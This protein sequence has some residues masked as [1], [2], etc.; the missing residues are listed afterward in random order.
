M[1]RFEI[2][3]NFSNVKQLSV[4]LIV[5]S[6]FTMSLQLPA[7]QH[8]CEY[9][10]KFNPPIKNCSDIICP[11][12]S[13]GIYPDCNCTAMNFDYS[14]YLNKCFRVCPDNSTGYWPNCNCFRGGFDKA[15]FE[16]VECPSSTSSGIYP[17]CVCDDENSRFNAYKH[18]CET[19]PLDSSGTVPNCV[20]DDGAGKWFTTL[21]LKPMNPIT[22]NRTL[23]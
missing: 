7:D 5:L 2:R 20:C 9:D 18:Y 17:N 21:F 12:D 14:V 13:I 8:D 15:N 11:K 10:T 6:A 19:C 16:C 3:N 23:P 22:Y 1:L 4:Q